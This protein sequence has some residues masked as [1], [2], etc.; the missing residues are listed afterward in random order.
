MVDFSRLPADEGVAQRLGVEVGEPV[1][2]LQRVRLANDQP[3]AFEI[4]YL[5]VRLCP[6][7]ERFDFS[8]ASLYAVLRE[9]YRVFPTWQKRK[10]RL[11]PLRL[12]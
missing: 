5:P 9:H 2:C 10:S 8:T 12:K 3:V 11:A 1:Y 7:L 6:D 4:A